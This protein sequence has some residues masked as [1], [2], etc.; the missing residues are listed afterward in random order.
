MALPEEDPRAFD[1]FI[2][3]LFFHK[4]AVLEFL[5]EYHNISFAKMVEVKMLEYEEPWHHLLCMASKFCCPE[6]EKE[7]LERIKT[8]HK[9]TRTVCHPDLLRDDLNNSP[10]AKGLV[11]YILQEFGRIEHGPAEDFAAMLDFLHADRPD[12]MIRGLK[13][14][15]EERTVYSHKTKKVNGFN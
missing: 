4:L 10:P 5:P 7:A 9:A 15:Q 11:N 8:F 3:W 12:L 6:L 1:L 2:H 13:K 14:S